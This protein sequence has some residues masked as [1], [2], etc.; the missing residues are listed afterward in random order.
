MAR[1]LNKADVADKPRLA[2]DLIASS[3]LLGI[4]QDDPECW[5]ARDTGADLEP[6]EIESRLEARAVAREARDFARADEIRDEL[7]SLGIAIED[8]PRGTTWRRT[9]GES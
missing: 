4:A 6:S 7:A 5:F 9:G 1:A 2:A 3:E 8:G